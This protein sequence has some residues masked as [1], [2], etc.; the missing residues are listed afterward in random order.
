MMSA[1]SFMPD[2]DARVE[3]TLV[4]KLSMLNARLYSELEL[5]DKCLSDDKQNSDN[6]DIKER[7]MYYKDEVISAM[8]AVRKTADEL[9]VN[10]AR[11]YWPY[12]TYGELLFSGD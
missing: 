4:T 7:A 6:S 8:N 10:V 1:L 2:A 11:D 5:L 12:P 3:K 9:E